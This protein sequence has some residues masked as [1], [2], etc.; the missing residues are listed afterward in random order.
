MSNEKVSTPPVGA[1]NSFFSSKI[2]AAPFVP[3]SGGKNSVLNSNNGGSGQ[4]FNLQ[5]AKAAPF[6][7]SG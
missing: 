6:V 5:S 7:P 2:N 3:G 1:P 4:S